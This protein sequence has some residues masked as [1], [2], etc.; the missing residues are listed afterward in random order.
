MFFDK[1]TTASLQRRFV[2][3]NAS[4]ST[5]LAQQCRHLVD[6]L[7]LAR[8]DV[9]PEPLKLGVTE[10]RLLAH[11]DGAGVMRDHRADEGASDH[12]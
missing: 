4:T 6:L 9:L 3:V 12:G 1:K 10:P 8:D 7:R 11:E 2:T 5:I